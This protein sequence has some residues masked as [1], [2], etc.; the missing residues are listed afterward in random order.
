VFLC[1]QFG[2]RDSLGCKLEADNTQARKQRR[3]A[4]CHVAASP[5]PCGSHLVQNHLTGG[6]HLCHVADNHWSTSAIINRLL[7]LREGYLNKQPIRSCHLSSINLNLCINQLLITHV[8]L[9]LENLQV[10]PISQIYESVVH[11]QATNQVYI[12]ILIKI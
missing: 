12:E 8:N 5:H 9:S 1:V 11:E 3:E 2:D 10:G 7:V 6:S 4:G